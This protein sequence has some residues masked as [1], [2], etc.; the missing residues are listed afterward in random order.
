[1]I[2]NRR[3]CDQ[4][5]EQFFLQADN[6]FRMELESHELERLERNAP[7]GPLDNSPQYL[8]MKL[9]VE[10]VAPVGDHE[11]QACQ[12][13]IRRPELAERRGVASQTAGGP[14][15]HFQTIDD[16]HVFDREVLHGANERVDDACISVGRQGF[17]SEGS[18]WLSVRADGLKIPYMKEALWTGA[19]PRLGQYLQ[20]TTG[21]LGG[22]RGQADCT[23]E[24]VV[25][26]DV[27]AISRNVKSVEM[28]RY[29]EPAEDGGDSRS[30][31]SNVKLLQFIA[32]DRWCDGSVRRLLKLVVNLDVQSQIHERL[33]A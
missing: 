23:A 5:L 13:R 16:G 3:P 12:S 10:P 17:Q 9:R 19:T 21:T 30:V 31:A 15:T 20:P 2:L 1:M 33:D 11:L 28:R 25:N 18:D 29:V 4:A 7:R 32:Q 6:M 22:S 14:L 8:P 26:L 24:C 27:P